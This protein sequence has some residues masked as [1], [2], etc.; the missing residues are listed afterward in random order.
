MIS[1]FVRFY[2]FFKKKLL[3]VILLSACVSL[4]SAIF[5]KEK[6]GIYLNFM[7]LLFLTEFLLN[8]FNL[9]EEISFK[10]FIKINGRTLL[11]YFFSFYLIFT[12]I[13]MLNYA[14]LI[15]I[16]GYVTA[17]SLNLIAI[18]QIYAKFLP[19]IRQ[20][21]FPLLAIFFIYLFILCT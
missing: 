18:L 3:F 10:R 8:D 5:V 2:F 13:F 4:F 7:T 15:Y 21:M 6:M 20:K 1:Y 11:P 14:S 19:K 12:C 17:I 9:E 16:K